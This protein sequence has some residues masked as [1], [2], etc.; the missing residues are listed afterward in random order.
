MSFPRKRRISIAIQFKKDA[1]FSRGLKRCAVFAIFNFLKNAFFVPKTAHLFDVFDQN[2]HAPI[3]QAK[4]APFSRQLFDP[5]KIPEN[6]HFWTSSIF[7]KKNPKDAPFSG[8]A[9]LAH[10]FDSICENFYNL[11]KKMRRFRGVFFAFSRF[12][13]KKAP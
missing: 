1:P 9:N 8:A 3:S 5:P 11:Q 12:L 10:L 13:G 4:D 7:T 2:R 6:H